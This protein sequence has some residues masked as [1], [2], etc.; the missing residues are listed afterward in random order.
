[1]GKAWCIAHWIKHD[2][3]AKADEIIA[4]VASIKNTAQWLSGY[5]PAPRTYLSQRRWIDGDAPKPFMG[6]LV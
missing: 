5:E 2:L 3:E 1:V 4:H 6:R